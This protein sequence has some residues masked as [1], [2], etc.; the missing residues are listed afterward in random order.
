MGAILG[1]KIDAKR[2]KESIDLA[3][4]EVDAPDFFVPFYR[5][6]LLSLVAVFP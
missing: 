4:Y 1:K 2:L 3:A 6:D 5:A